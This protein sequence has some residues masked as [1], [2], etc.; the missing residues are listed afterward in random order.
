MYQ[1]D[2]KEGGDKMQMVLYD[3]R[4]NKHN[5]SQK[6]MAEFLDISVVTYRMKEKGKS[7]FTQDEMFKVS[8][9]FKK[10]IEDIFLPRWYQY[11]NKEEQHT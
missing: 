2:N 8:R 5:M 1:G 7:E 3:L 10:N 4:K 11:G 9:L 6:E